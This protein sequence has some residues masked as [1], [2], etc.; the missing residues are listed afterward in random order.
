MKKRPPKKTEKVAHF[1]CFKTW[2]R[3]V[4]PRLPLA[5][6]ASALLIEL[7]ALSLRRAR[8]KRVRAQ[9]TLKSVPND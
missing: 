2:T 1:V 3:P 8:V 4:L 9:Q 5:C 6:H 7:R